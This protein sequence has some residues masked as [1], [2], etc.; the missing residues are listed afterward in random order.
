MKRNSIAILFLHLLVFGFL[1]AGR[2]GAQTAS[3][4]RENTL[5]RNSRIKT[6]SLDLFDKKR[7]RPVPVTLYSSDSEAGKAKFKK[8]KLAIINHGY[9]MKNTEYSFI[10]ETL[11]RQGYFVASIQHEL[12]TDEPMPT[13]GKPSEV[14]RPF[15]ERGVQNILFVIDELKKSRRDLDFKNLLLVGHSNGGDTAMLFA[16]KYPKPARK[17]ISLDN[18]R[19]ALPRA[20]RPQIL[21][22]RSSD[23]TADEG[24]LPTAEEQEKFGIK[25]IKLKNTIHNDMWDG[26]TEA[27]KNEIS[28]II[29]DF[30][31]DRSKNQTSKWRKADLE[32]TF[33]QIAEIAKGRVGIAAMLLETGELIALNGDERFPMQSV[34]KLPIAMAVL[35]EID[36]GKIN[37]DQTVR[38]KKSDLVG[39]HLRSPI[40]D[41]YPDGTELPVSELLRLMVSESDGTACDVLLKLMGGPAAVNDY[42][43]GF[44]IREMN[45]VNNEKEIGADNKTQYRNYATPEAA[46]MLLRVLHEGKAISPPSRTLL[47][48][49]MIET[50]TGRK[51]L[52]GL[53]PKDVVVAH[54]TG[55]SNT[56]N[57]VT[58]A[59]N[60]IGLITLPDGRHLAVAVFVS[61]SPADEATREAVIA[62]IA[63][64]VWDSCSK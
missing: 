8:Q 44:N 13:V 31:A 22:I 64:A 36:A 40:R 54:K 21:S 11:L 9:G 59:T 34:F 56:V 20:K 41:K 49:L 4:G 52:K 1:T 57:G 46:I 6:E 62:K 3:G 7:R 53:L 23:Q 19:M 61:D 58:A 35:R 10:A 14:R 26:A 60:D 15:W 25:I 33:K 45:V 12:P 51:R 37:F 18:R 2:T 32:N 16:E 24:V 55:T 48:K 28:S 30:L 5:N 43:R 42:L 17:I 29:S 50:P 27:Q 47:L 38:I 39:K 63:R